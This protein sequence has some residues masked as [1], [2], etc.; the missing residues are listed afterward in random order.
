MA[1]K[2]K[3]TQFTVVLPKDMGDRLKAEA[4]ARIVSPNFLIVRAV[5]ELL[6]NL[7]VESPES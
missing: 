3:T 1:A 5:R 2:A 4:E 6:A 7:P